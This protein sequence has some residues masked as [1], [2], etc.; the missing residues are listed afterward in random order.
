MIVRLHHKHRAGVERYGLAHILNTEN[1]KEVTALLLG[2]ADPE[3]IF[4]P[5]DIRVGLGVDKGELLDFSIT[6][7]G[8]AGALRWYMNAK[9]P[10]ISIP[11]WIA[12][13]GLLL[14]VLSLI[15]SLWPSC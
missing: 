4:M 1:D 10:A 13:I 6:R 14:G 9:D 2:H 5:Y 8:L 3:S 7:V 15:I 12:V 11:A